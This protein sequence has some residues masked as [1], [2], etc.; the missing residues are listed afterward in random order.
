MLKQDWLAVKEGDVYPTQFD[1]GAILTG[2]LLARAT[3]L[4][5]LEDAPKAAL[6]APENK[7]QTRK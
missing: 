1:K 2:E 7:A 5:L 4:G 3:A 6:A